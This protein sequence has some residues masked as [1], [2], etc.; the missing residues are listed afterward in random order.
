MS[1]P[2]SAAQLL[3]PAALGIGLPREMS[4]VSGSH[5]AYGVSTVDYTHPARGLKGTSEWAF[6]V[7][8]R[9]QG[10]EVTR[11]GS[12][13][14]FIPKVQGQTVWGIKSARATSLRNRAHRAGNLRAGQT[15]SPK[16]KGAEF[17]GTADDFTTPVDALPGFTFTYKGGWRNPKSPEK[18]GAA[19]ESILLCRGIQE[20]QLHPCSSEAKGTNH[21]RLGG[22][23]G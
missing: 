4:T 18:F 13:A 21:Q 10:E 12:H 14:I 8:E 22:G 19:R 5:S 20:S 16:S 1:P 6:P 3:S 11:E 15:P 9:K 17:A 7:R 2:T 23:G